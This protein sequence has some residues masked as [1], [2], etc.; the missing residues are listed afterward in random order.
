MEQTHRTWWKRLCE[1]GFITACIGKRNASDSTVSVYP[2]EAGIPL[3]PSFPLFFVA[4]TFVDRAVEV[5]YYGGSTGG[6]QV[7]TPFLCLILKLL[8]IQPEK[9][10]VVEFIKNEDY[11][12]CFTQ[13]MPTL[14]S[15]TLVQLYSF[16]WRILS[17]ID[18]DAKGHLSVLGASL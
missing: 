10:I 3:T 9:E 6:A 2:A 16:A 12:Y 7:P 8:Q 11:R 15:F 13:S 18:R 17:S 4:E 1:I 5:K 14:F